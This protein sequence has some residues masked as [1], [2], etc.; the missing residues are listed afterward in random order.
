MSFI[1]IAEMLGITFAVILGLYILLRLF[2]RKALLK[3]TLLKDRTAVEA[4]HY[5]YLPTASMTVKAVATV[6]VTKSADNGELIDAKLLQLVLDV[7]TTVCPDTSKM[8]TLNYGGDIY[9]N[10]ELR[11][12]TKENGL[13]DNISAVVEDRISNIISQVAQAPGKILSDQIARREMYVA[14]KIEAKEIIAQTLEFTRTFVISQSDANKKEFFTEWIIPIEG[15]S[16]SGPKEVDA[17]FKLVNADHAG[18][19]DFSVKDNDVFAFSGVVTRPLKLFNWDVHLVKKQTTGGVDSNKVKE[20]GKENKPAPENANEQEKVKG[21]KKD[22]DETPSTSFSC[23]MP[24]SSLLVKIPVTR[25]FFVKKTSLPKFSNGILI[26]NYISKP[27]E[28]EGFVSI[29]INIL[30]AIVSIPAQLFQFRITRNNQEAALE[31]SVQDLLKAR[32]ITSELQRSHAIERVER[33][34]LQR[35]L[36][37][38]QGQVNNLLLGFKPRAQQDPGIPKLGKLPAHKPGKIKSLVELIDEIRK[39]NKI[40]EWVAVDFPAAW[41]WHEKQGESWLSYGNEQIRNCVPAAAAH[42]VT[43]WTSHTSQQARIPSVEDVNAAY[44]R[45]SGYDPVTGANDRGCE[46]WK[47]M[48]SWEANGLGINKCRRSATIPGK[49]RNDLKL[50][51]YWF[52]SCM[53]GFDMPISAQGQMET[54]EVP[55]GGATGD[56]KP[57]TW[58]GHAVAAVGYNKDHLIVISWGRVIKVS[59]SFYETYNDES[60]VVLSNDWVTENSPSPSNKDFAVLNKTIG[61][62]QG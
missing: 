9:S 29:P 44:S 60:Y 4:D 19:F 2:H 53:I 8:F 35:E 40:K 20:G 15:R 34:T 45:E 3:S 10:D 47:W 6:V 11:I 27:S 38:T 21:I 55:V 46:V 51:I 13:L 42:M 26:E 16:N 25:A 57:G 1:Q 49:S 48:G 22:Y 43:C 58:E 62:L 7:Q 14:P 50:G 37:K 31:K 54:W 28:L 59:W 41:S 23:L 32:D 61:D 24:D 18:A 17:S 33:E 39:V 30:K 52:G 56:G 5:Y 36:S 12:K